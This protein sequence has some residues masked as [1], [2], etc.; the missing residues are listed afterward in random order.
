MAE[1]TIYKVLDDCEIKKLGERSYEFTAS[2]STEDRMGEVIEA[3]GWDLKNFKKN[4]VIM[5]AHDYHSLP[6]ARAPRVWVSGDSLKNVVEFPPEGTYEFADTVE[7][8][9]SA[10][11][12]KAESVGFI[13]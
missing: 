12:L 4:P 10:G 8:I 5:F 9:I 6:I 1:N 13:P 7:R 3:K 11:Y 2:M